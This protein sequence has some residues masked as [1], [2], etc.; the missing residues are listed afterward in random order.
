MMSQIAAIAAPREVERRQAAPITREGAG[1]E[2]GRTTRPRAE[3]NGPSAASRG[4][5]STADPSA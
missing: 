4:H 5:K 1:G 2:N 3:A